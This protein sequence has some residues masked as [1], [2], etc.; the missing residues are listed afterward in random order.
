MITSPADPPPRRP[1]LRR[2]LLRGV[3]WMLIGRVASMA[4]L[5]AVNV[6]LARRMGDAELGAYLLASFL[7]PFFAQ[8]MSLG[9]TDIALRVVRRGHVTGDPDISRAMIRACLILYVASGAVVS[10]VLVVLCRVL[11]EG[12]P[13][14]QLL[15]ESAHW[16]ALW[17]LLYTGS[18]LTSELFR[19]RDMFGLSTAMFS[20]SGGW[21]SN[22]LTLGAIAAASLASDDLDLP[23]VLGLHVAMLALAVLVGGALAYRDLWLRPG[24]APLEGSGDAAASDIPSRPT[25]RWM[26]SQSW[27]ISV[28][29]GTLLGIEQLDIFVVSLFASDLDVADFGFAKRCLVL[30]NFAFVTVS[31]ALMPFIAELFERGELRKLERLVR[32]TATL[33]GLPC[34]ALCVAVFAIAPWFA[35]LVF[36]AE[37]AGVALPLRILIAGQAFLFLAGHGQIVLL[38]TGQ[39]RK[40]M[41]STVVIGS[42]FALLCP[43]A[44]FW[45]GMAGAAVVK[46]L[47]TAERSA[48]AAL[49][50]RKT[51]GIGTTA[52]LSP[53]VIRDSIQLVLNT[54]RPRRAT[55]ASP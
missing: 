23:L 53:A 38:M 7:V 28:S 31:P 2:R 37:H 14:W 30:I 22:V 29:A 42:V 13:A 55:E 12:R 35:T 21:L 17:M 49:I 39:Q 11:A 36:G 40:L 43:L 47:A 45:Y 8:L 44:T 48:A 3:S 41:V 52:S 33:V 10:A 1:S 4:S 24:P 5:F 26:L 18:Q 25:L 54:A 15:S 50:V 27:P 6:L 19:G 46:S 34:V 9:T 16:F 20:K 51:L 32:G